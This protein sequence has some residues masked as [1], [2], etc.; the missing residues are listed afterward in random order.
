MSIAIDQTRLRHIVH[1]ILGAGSLTR[2]EATT[3]LQMTQIAAGVELESDYA[4]R[5]VLQAIAQQVCSYAGGKSDELLP[6]QT[7]PEHGARTSWLHSLAAHLHSCGARELAYALVFLVSVGDLE[8]TRAERAALE[9]FQHALGL[10]HRRA[11]D[12]V[13]FLTET[14]AG[15]EPMVADV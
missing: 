9:E 8:L 1:T 3:I 2:D 10:D 11:T 12:L 14:V 7:A 6:I 13:V 4:Q 5:A 15:G